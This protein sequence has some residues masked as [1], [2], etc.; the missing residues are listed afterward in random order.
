[1]ITEPNWISHLNYPYPTT[2]QE[3]N[4]LYTLK[5]N[6]GLII[7]PAYKGYSDED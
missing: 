4:A 3:R 5:N 1:M 7:L 6:N 2:K